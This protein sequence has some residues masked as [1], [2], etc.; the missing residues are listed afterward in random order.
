MIN[1]AHVSIDR[2]AEFTPLSPS[3]PRDY[4]IPNSRNGRITLGRILLRF[5]LL[6][7]ALGIA[8]VFVAIT[9]ISEGV[10]GKLEDR[11]VVTGEARPEDE[12]SRRMSGQDLFQDIS[13]NAT[14]DQILFGDLHVHTTF[15]G[16]AFIFSL[17]LFQGEGAHPPADACDFARF[18]SGLD[19]W[20]INDHAEH[21]TPRQWAE[22]RESIRECNAVTTPENPDTVAFL[23]WEW[24]QSAPANLQGDRTHYGHKNVILLETGEGKVP[25]RPIGAGGGGLFAAP[26]PSAAWALLRA[27]M[28][29]RDLDQLGPYLDFNRF[30]REAR[31]IDVCPEGVPVQQLPKDCLEGAETPEILFR[32]LDEWGLPSLVIPHGTSWGIHAPATAS[33]DQQLS[34]G[35]HDPLR[36]RLF[37]VYSGHGNSEIYR[38]GRDV[39]VDQDGNRTCS[40]PQDNYL[41]CCWRAGELI[42]ER[43]EDGLSESE[44]ESRVE[45]TRQLAVEAG[46]PYGVVSGTIASD[47]MECGQ[48]QDGFLPAFDY[49]PHMSAQYGLSVVGEDG[50]T[51]RYGLI[52]SSDNH[53]AR[54]GAGYKEMPRSPMSDAYGLRSDWLAGL[55]AE[56]GPDPEPLDPPAGLAGLLEG[57][58]RGASFYYTGGLVAVHSAARDRQSIWDALKARRVY[59]T[60]GDR[61]LLHFDLL[62]G[63]G[64]RVPMG[65][66]VEV[67][68]P[69]RFEVRAL[70]AFEQLPGCPETVQERLSPERIKRLCLGECYNPSDQ[71][72]RIERIEV[73]RIRKQLDPEDPVSELIE[74]P[75]RSF[76]CPGSRAGCTAVFEDPDP[77][78][79]RENVYYVRAIQEPTLVVNGSPVRCERDEHGNCIRALSC[80]VSGPRLDLEDPC[81][82]EAGERAWSSP[83]FVRVK[84]TEQAD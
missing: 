78:P 35:Q 60:S 57:F 73:V 69:P 72:L 20:S 10:G 18:C 65:S 68:T 71:R 32:K 56:Q 28:A 46:S 53:T 40:P 36:Q 58:E 34:Q 43:C 12:I 49:R 27:G 84:E 47:W 29:A 21:L 5:V 79:E 52:G 9:L 22:T 39:E 14:D 61:I 23:G 83:I 16:D 3:P 50:S 1:D 64:A 48:L 17:P 7:L 77:D 42:R 2:L 70:G 45:R 76:D 51:F 62:D 81:L 80:P 6:P 8:A 31:S 41:P 4:H 66:E 15:S 25:T 54:P 19:F 38:E 63:P 13:R 82:W 26:V 24:T 11:G 37:E 44:C 30:A 33:L 67:T 59:G 75:W 74:D 55:E